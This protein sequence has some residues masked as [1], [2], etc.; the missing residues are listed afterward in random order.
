[1]AIQQDFE[2]RY[3]ARNPMSLVM[4]PS[5]NVSSWT[6][7]FVLCDNLTKEVLAELTDDLVLNDDEDGWDWNLFPYLLEELGPGVQYHWYLERIDDGEEIV[8]AEGVCTILWS[9]V[10]V[11]VEV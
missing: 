10:D 1:M 11:S 7:R 8:I 6:V 5:Q 9:P 4:D 3:K 2:V